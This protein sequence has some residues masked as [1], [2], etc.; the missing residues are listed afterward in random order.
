M[1]NFFKSSKVYVISDEESVIFYVLYRHSDTLMI[2]IYNYSNDL[3]THCAELRWGAVACPST[4]IKEAFSHK[5]VT[6]VA[7]SRKHNKDPVPV[8]DS[9]VLPPIQTKCQ[10][11][12]SKKNI[13]ND[14]FHNNYVGLLNKIAK[15]T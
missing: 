7:A 6:V 3:Y 15:T 8:C 1:K 11:K 14:V 5:D 9:L 2:K 13:R 12:M 4:C 10:H